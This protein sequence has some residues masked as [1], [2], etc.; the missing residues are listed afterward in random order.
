MHRGIPLNYPNTS[1]IQISTDIPVPQSSAR[2][3]ENNTEELSPCSPLHYSQFKGK[4]SEEQVVV[5]EFC[6]DCDVMSG[7]N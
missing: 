2:V 4:Q 7:G 6:R 3:S 1:Q 5:G